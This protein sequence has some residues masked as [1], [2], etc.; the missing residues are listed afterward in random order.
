M[1][2]V[3]RNLLVLMFAVLIALQAGILV[4]LIGMRADLLQWACG[5]RVYP[6]K[7]V[8]MPDR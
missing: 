3:R 2:W 4:T 5:T 8:L 1:E 6:C 7:V